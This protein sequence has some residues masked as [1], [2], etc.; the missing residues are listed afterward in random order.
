MDEY[1]YEE[2][3]LR[4]E[5]ERRAAL[6]RAAQEAADR[7]AAK[8]QNA[9]DAAEQ[10]QQ[11]DSQSYN[12]NEPDQQQPETFMTGYNPKNGLPEFSKLQPDYT[13]ADTT[14]V[15]NN[16][17]EIPNAENPIDSYSYE[18]PENDMRVDESG[19]VAAEHQP[20]EDY[21]SYDPDTYKYNDSS[22]AVGDFNSEDRTDPSGY[23]SPS[24][25]QQNDFKQPQQKPQQ[26]IT[27]DK[28]GY[29]SHYTDKMGN[30][31][32]NDATAPEYDNRNGPLESPTMIPA[33]QT[34]SIFGDYMKGANAIVTRTADKVGGYLHPS[35]SWDNQS[36]NLVGAYKDGKYYK[37]EQG[38]GGPTL[39]QVANREDV[40]PASNQKYSFSDLPVADGKSKNA[41][42]STANPAA[43]TND[44]SNPTVNPTV[45]VTGIIGEIKNPETEALQREQKLKSEFEYA[46]KNSNIAKVSPFENANIV[47]VALSKV[48]LPDV[49]SLPKNFNDANAVVGKIENDLYKEIGKI[50]PEDAVL[51][52]KEL[53]NIYKNASAKDLDI[54]RNIVQNHASSSNTNYSNTTGGSS[55]STRSNS[56]TDTTSSSKT[57]SSK[58]GGTEGISEGGRNY[59]SSSGGTH[60]GDR[61]GSSSNSSTSGSESHWG[62]TKSNSWEHGSSDTTGTSSSNTISSSDSTTSNYSNTKGGGE[63]QS[64]GSTLSLLDQKLAKIGSLT[65]LQKSLAREGWKE[66]ESRVANAEKSVANALRPYYR[67]L[68]KG[69]DPTSTD[70]KSFSNNS[71]KSPDY[72]IPNGVS[73]F[74]SGSNPQE[75]SFVQNDPSY[76][77]ALAN[78]YNAM[79]AD[80]RANLAFT[81]AQ[82]NIASGNYNPKIGETFAYSGTSSNTDIHKIPIVSAINERS[83]FNTSAGERVGETSDPTGLLGDSRITGSIIN[84]ASGSPSSQALLRGNSLT[85]DEKGTV[86]MT[87][88]TLQGASRAHDYIYP[89]INKYGEPE[90]TASGKPFKAEFGEVVGKVYKDYMANPDDVNAKI[91]A[92]GALDMLRRN[93]PAEFNDPKMEKS[94]LLRFLNIFNNAVSEKGSQTDMLQQM[95]D[96]RSRKYLNDEDLKKQKSIEN[97]S[98]IDDMELKRRLSSI[99]Y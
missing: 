60:S 39:R 77:R 52:V 23:V 84:M 16:A 79:L 66:Y 17:A 78:K 40:I 25:Y 92:F 61:S 72:N 36:Y 7:E 24:V 86:A 38:E 21:Y 34:A 62:K 1:N 10:I 56:T 63:S 46:L 85:D 26:T 54:A 68:E 30:L 69:I 81:G 43:I 88:N 12:Y 71:A 49:R 13:E 27:H 76:N 44:S 58:Y 11:T 4:A 8:E 70:A 55:T 5:M 87:I 35:D 99:P 2:E 74:R 64:K 90:L 51:A 22:I 75:V 32:K 50:K 73:S 19:S 15:Q 96:P 9:R 31:I 82:Q 93:Y 59:Q 14:D 6:A 57:L 29:P 80:P 47:D 48:F 95:Y 45:G 18:I 65:E 98:R 67:H 37:A 94:G 33:S 89:K 83:A 20:I 28:N 91:Q 53:K 41:N 3:A 42:Q 97:R